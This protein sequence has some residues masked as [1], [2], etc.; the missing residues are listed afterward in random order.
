VA[1][2]LARAAR[3][4]GA[5]FIVNDRADVARL[6][7]AAGV[8][9]G[10]LDL[11]P[12]DARLVVGDAAVVG[13]STHDDDQA[14][15]AADEPV[16]YVAIGPVFATSSKAR[17]DPVVGL[18]GVMTAR[19]IVARSRRPLVAIGGITLATAPG[20]IAAGADSVAVISDLLAGDPGARARQF[21]RALA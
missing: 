10:Q 12:R 4:A 18:E 13:L 6:S 3:G 7:G 17:P 15:R 9:L 16:D 2:E 21:L 8:H 5:T 19:A 11:V 1:E 20:V 14:R